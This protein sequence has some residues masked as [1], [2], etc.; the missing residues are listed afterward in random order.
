[1][2]H[3]FS[4]NITCKIGSKK[5]NTMGFYKS[6]EMYLDGLNY[7]VN[8]FTETRFRTEE[9][10]LKVAPQGLIFKQTIFKGEDNRTL[11]RMEHSIFLFS[12]TTTLLSLCE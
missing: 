8:I 10:I 1:M 6:M 5:G 3:Y 7:T 12:N 4:Q 2:K 11:E 9:N